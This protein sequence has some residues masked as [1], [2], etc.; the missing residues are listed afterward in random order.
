MNDW[1]WHGLINNTGVHQMINV[2]LE[3]TYSCCDIEKKK[4]RLIYL[5]I[6]TDRKQN[7]SKEVPSNQLL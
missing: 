4:E 3:T 6:D 7:S 2:C 1:I 5:L